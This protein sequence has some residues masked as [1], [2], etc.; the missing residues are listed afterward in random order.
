MNLFGFFR[1]MPPIDDTRALADF[2]DAQ[3]AFIVQ[4]G[5]YDYTQARAGHYTKVLLKEQ[6]FIES[7][8]R[9]RWQAYPL[10]LAMIGEL[11]EGVLHSHA[12]ED[13][14]ALLD[15][16][17]VL[18]LS[19]FDRYPVPPLLGSDTWQ[20]ARTELTR[21]L[22]QIGTHPPK[23]AIDIPLPY[24]QRYFDL[25]PFHKDLLTRD[26]PTARSYLQINLTNIRDELIKRMDA[27]AL[28]ESMIANLTRTY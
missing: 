14:R 1:R 20:A 22:S 5:I 19:V 25:M 17:L 12:M 2:I 23:R 15:A 10:G 13:R 16:L 27:Q 6:G 11:V 3:S 9:S 26:M 8:E 4:K 24:A 28:V 21:K 7:F 18:V